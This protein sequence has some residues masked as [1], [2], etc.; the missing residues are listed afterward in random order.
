MTETGVGF[1]E[2]RIDF[3]SFASVRNGGFEVR[4]LRVGG[5]TI[6]CGSIVRVSVGL[7]CDIATVDSER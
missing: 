6:V 3:E 2:G 1:A 7:K 4:D 5:G